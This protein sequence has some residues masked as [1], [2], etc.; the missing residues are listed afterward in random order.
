M[1]AMLQGWSGRGPL[2]ACILTGSRRRGLDIR[3]AMGLTGI[4]PAGLETD[5]VGLQSIKQN[6]LEWRN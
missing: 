1:P 6:L 5:A 2:S 4:P 3:T